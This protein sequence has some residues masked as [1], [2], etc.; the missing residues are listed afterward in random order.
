MRWRWPAGVTPSRSGK[1]WPGGVARLHAVALH[2]GHGDR[3]PARGARPRDQQRIAR[4]SAAGERVGHWIK[5]WTFFKLA[6]QAHDRPL[7]TLAGQQLGQLHIQLLDVGDRLVP[8]PRAGLL[9]QI[10]RRDRIAPHI[11]VDHRLEHIDFDHGLQPATLLRPLPQ[12]RQF[13]ESL[14]PL[15]FGIIAMAHGLYPAAHGLQLGVH[16]PYLLHRGQEKRTKNQPCNCF[17]KASFIRNLSGISFY[18]GSNVLHTR[19]TLSGS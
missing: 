4:P 3:V 2:G 10:Q 17:H 12:P 8:E 7:V 11:A 19:N 9:D 1:G 15:G 5:V 13:L 6:N 14:R 18:H 16:G